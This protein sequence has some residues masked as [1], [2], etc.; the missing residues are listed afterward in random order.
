MVPPSQEI[1]PYIKIVLE[2]PRGNYITQEK[3][4]LL[5]A[6][7]QPPLHP[8]PKIFI[9]CPIKNALCIKWVNSIT[10][11]PFLRVCGGSGHHH[12]HNY[13]TFQLC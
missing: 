1:P 9:H 11:N 8:P 12:R 3:Y 6:R 10:Y 7:L 2:T 13:L 4:V 5:T